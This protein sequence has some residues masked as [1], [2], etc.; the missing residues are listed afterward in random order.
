MLV[1]LYKNNVV[2]K[3]MIRYPAVSVIIL[4]YNREQYVRRAIE[5]ILSQTLEDFEFIL[6]DNGSE[7]SSG[8]ICDEYAKKD[9]RI[10][11]I[12]KMKGNIGSGRNAGLLA[13]RGKYIAFIDDD[14]TAE[15]D[16]LEFLYGLITKYKAD[17]SICGS[18]RSINGILKP[19]Y[20]YGNILDLN[21]EQSIVELLKRE[22]YN[23][24]FPCKMIRR[25]IILPPPFSEKGRYDDVT[26]TYK[27]FTKARK[28]IA[29]GLPKYTF[30]RHKTNNSG[31][32]IDYELL[33]PDILNEYLSA[34]RERTV[35]LSE[36]FPR[37]MDYIRYAE[38]S[39]MISMCEKITRYGIKD[40]CKQLYYM[41][42]ILKI[43]LREITSS[44]NLRESERDW[45]KLRII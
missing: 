5:S 17:I 39:Y 37:I 28:I 26:T 15:P 42:D 23:V 30:Y 8:N 25:E 19:K 38:W 20:I 22:Y 29:Y 27:V 43:N 31:F 12:H 45:L 41:E 33:K 3:Y 34:Y 35:Y 36:K 18:W 10:K 24:T 14:D 21:T 7:D 44:I 11:V 4:T 6:V 9:S 13:A 40:C 1:H 2:A 32:I 16:M